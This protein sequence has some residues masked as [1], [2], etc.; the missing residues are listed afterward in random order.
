MDTRVTRVGQIEN[1]SRVISTRNMFD[2]H[3]DFAS[4]HNNT[5]YQHARRVMLFLTNE[6]GLPRTFDTAGEF[7]AKVI[8]QVRDKRDA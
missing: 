4:E 3:F 6:N 2:M 1:V 7:A 5:R 8:T